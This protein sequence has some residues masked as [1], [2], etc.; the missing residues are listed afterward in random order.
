MRE[1]AGCGVWRYCD[2]LGELPTQIEHVPYPMR[3]NPSI[4]S[5]SICVLWTFSS[6]SEFGPCISQEPRIFS[7]CS[8]VEHIHSVLHFSRNSSLLFH[9]LD[10]YI[11]SA[12]HSSMSS[13]KPKRALMQS[14]FQSQGSPILSAR[15]HQAD[16]KA[17]QSKKTNLSVG[18]QKIESKKEAQVDATPKP[19]Q[20]N[21]D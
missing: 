2:C 16:G 8:R 15:Q 10:F 21:C 19:R 11:G 18:Q 13:I 20:Y 9:F 17:E 5:L 1:A 4:D 12:R 3:T 6:N 14:L 7:F